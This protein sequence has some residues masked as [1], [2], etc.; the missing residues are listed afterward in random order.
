MKQQHI[1][2]ADLS[3]QHHK[4]IFKFHKNT[5]NWHKQHNNRVA[6]F[7]KDH[8]AKIERGENGNGILAKWERFVY[9]KYKALLKQ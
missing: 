3:R 9:N 1:D 7:H 5:N 8:A 2:R 4:R 6:E